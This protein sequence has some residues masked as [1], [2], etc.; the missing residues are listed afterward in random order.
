MW[1]SEKSEF[2]LTE[3]IDFLFGSIVL[4]TA[5]NVNM[6]LRNIARPDSH[7]C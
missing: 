2:H 7:Y 3:K 1:K 5:S 6:E 4:A